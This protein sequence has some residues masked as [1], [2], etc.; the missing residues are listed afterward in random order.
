MK[1]NNKF[2][3]K[4]KARLVSKKKKQYKEKCIVNVSN[5]NVNISDKYNDVKLNWK[6]AAGAN[7]YHVYYK[8]S[9][10][11][12]YALAGTTSGVSY[13]IKDLDEG[14]KYTF[15]VV[16]VYMTNDTV[17]AT[18][19]S[20]TVTAYTL[21]QMEAPIVEY[22]SSTK[23]IVSWDNINGESGYQISRSTDEE[24]TNIVSTCATTTG[25]SKILSVKKDTTYYYKLRVYKTVN[26]KKVY[27]PWSD[28]TEFIND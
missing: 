7:Q 11:E 20:K 16:P 6:K 17:A 26:G 21:K 23:V 10:D 24:G 2:L 3:R 4:V 18:G 14:I 8:K 27:G 1:V 22:Y 13:K 25:E 5:L 12:E 9:I 28:V 19:G 15:K